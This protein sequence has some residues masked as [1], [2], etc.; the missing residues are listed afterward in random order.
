[1]YNILQGV[2]PK[3][4]IFALTRGYTTELWEVTTSCWKVDPSE[5]PTVDYV[6]AALRSSAEQRQPQHGEISALSPMN[7]RSQA[8]LIERSDSPIVPEHED[9]P[10]TITVTTPLHSPRPPIIRTPVPLARTNP[11]SIRSRT[12]DHKE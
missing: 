5:R 6:L 11:H 2:R 8:L 3:A 9:K 10:A 1:M 12:F 7:D 4:P